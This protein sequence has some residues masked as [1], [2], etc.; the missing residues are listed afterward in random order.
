M[1]VSAGA[2]PRAAGGAGI[3]FASWLRPRFKATWQ[4]LARDRGLDAAIAAELEFGRGERV[5]ASDRHSDGGYVVIATDR[6]L[7]HRVLRGGARADGW[8]RLGWEQI[9]RVGWDA[10]TGQ[11]IITSAVLADAVLADPVLAGAGPARIAVPLRQRGIIPEVAMEHVTHTRLGR[12][13]LLAGGARCAVIEARRRPATGELLWSVTYS[14]NGRGPAG[15]DL[16]AR[17]E[18]A[19]ARLSA[20]FGALPQP[21]L[22][23]LSAAIGRPRSG[24]KGAEAE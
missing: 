11:L 8:A 15:P 10:T 6:A 19:V 18:R 12:W 20:E 16:R 3:P 21:G 22:S 5:L 24:G 2:Q 14:G 9:A 4:N 1:T 17:A 7:Y 13:Q 23:P